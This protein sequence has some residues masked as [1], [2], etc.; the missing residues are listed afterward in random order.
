M[1]AR[2]ARGLFLI[3]AAAL[4]F[5]RPAAARQ[6]PQ[7]NDLAEA[8]GLS[9]QVVKLY[10]EA[11]YDEALP[12][13]KRALKIREKA[14]GREH[15]LTAAA[16]VNLAEQYWAKG[17]YGDAEPLLRRAL[18]AFE[19]VSGPQAAVAG[20]VLDRLASLSASKRDPSEAERLY[21]RAVS[22]KE[23]ALGPAHEEVVQTLNTLAGFYR[24]NSQPGKAVPLLRRVVEIRERAHGPAHP[25]TAEALQRL[26]CFL[27]RDKQ[28]GEAEKVEA[29]ANDILY[30]DAAAKS[31]PVA[32]P[33]EAFN[34]KMLS[35]PMPDL[36]ASAR[37]RT[38]SLTARIA[39][40][41]NEAGEVESARMVGGD[42]EMKKSA[43]RAALK[44]KFM[45]TLVG[46]RPVKVSGEIVHEFYTRTSIM[47]IGPVPVRQ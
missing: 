2:V 4:L 20:R 41:V 47:I 37:G 40:V 25:R 31:E 17:E 16:A 22:A 38:G 42:P 7:T 8:E 27:H 24:A 13:A 23:K 30:R 34:C 5:L 3:G 12:L 28:K 36:P 33:Q 39:V 6:Q 44:A 46:G 43:E 35:N 21:L 29:R 1:R 9:E 19:K 32:L 10:K 26:A 15:V 14:L 18:P 45:P 11:R